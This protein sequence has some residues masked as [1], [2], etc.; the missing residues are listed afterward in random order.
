MSCNLIQN[1]FTHCLCFCKNRFES[2]WLV[3][4]AYH[5][6]IDRIILS[7]SNY[8]CVLHYSN[9]QAFN[10]RVC[11]IE[12]IWVRLNWSWCWRRLFGVPWTARRSNQSILKEISTEYSLEGVMLKL[13]LQFFGHL[14]L[15]KRPWCWER[16]KAGGDGWMA[17]P[18]QWTWVWVNSGSWWWTGKPGVLQSMGSQRVRHNWVTELNWTEQ[19]ILDELAHLPENLT[20][21]LLIW[22]DLRWV[23]PDQ[24]EL[25][26]SDRKIGVTSSCSMSLSFS[27]SDQEQDVSFSWRWHRARTQRKIQVCFKALALAMFVNHPVKSQSSFRKQMSRLPR[28]D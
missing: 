1:V 4:E 19:L 9:K 13:K 15:W 12:L 16:L 25:I 27:S 17:S 2:T 10:L 6:S 26:P 21:Y 18:T 3:W 5:F 28:W 20:G 8:F 22:K 7:A 11:S 23:I 14:T 24:W